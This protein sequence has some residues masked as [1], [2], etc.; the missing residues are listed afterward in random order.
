MIDKEIAEIRKR[1]RSDKTGISKIR[2][3]YVNSHKEKMAELVQSLGTLTD[4]E[5]EAILNILKKTL[6]GGIGKNLID[7]EFSNE[8]VMNGEEHKLLMNLKNS[9]LSDEYVEELFDKIIESYDTE[10]NYLILLVC[11]KYDVPHRYKDGTQDDE[12]SDVFT[13]ILCSICPV[14]MTKPALSYYVASNEF[15]N[16]SPDWVVASPEAGFMFPCFDDRSA[17]IYNALY[18]TKSTTCSHDE[19]VDALFKTELPL[20]ASVQKETF[21]SV[22]SA[23]I[24]EECSL[25]VIQNVHEQ[26][27]EMID[28]HKVNKV[29]EPLVISKNVV[30]NILQ[31]NGIDEERIE[32]FEEHY[33]TE[34]GEKTEL[35]PSNLIDIKQIK[36]A[37]PDVKIN[38]NP[39]R[40][41]L[42]ETRVIDGRKYIMIRVDGGVEVNG[43][44]INITNENTGN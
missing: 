43:I 11:E 14:K 20:P 25:D 40:G 36:V 2:V 21:E 16:L 42:I 24:G 29:E 28:N 18:Y 33:N 17:N 15:H 23:S 19:L 3:C 34:F 1:F 26:L 30:K 7:I 37:T 44:N 38:V 41:D 35:N 32:T 10:E 5:E 8:Q 6:S 13:Y 22:I 12:G 27:R 4:K 9:E 31:S 39:D